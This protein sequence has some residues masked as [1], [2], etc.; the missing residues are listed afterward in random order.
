LL[1][2]LMGVIGDIEMAGGRATWEPADVSD[3]A[4]VR[5]L[6]DAADAATGKLENSVSESRAEFDSGKARKL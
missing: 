5:R 6:F 4:A 3:P 1:V 2:T